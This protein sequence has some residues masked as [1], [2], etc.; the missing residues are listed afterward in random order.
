MLER[1]P[2]LQ[3]RTKHLAFLV[4]SRGG[5]PEYQS[6]AAEVFKTVEAI[7]QKYGGEKGGPIEIYYENN[8]HHV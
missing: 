6:Y 1:H 5:V 4:P 7:N 2:E 3:A 8:Y